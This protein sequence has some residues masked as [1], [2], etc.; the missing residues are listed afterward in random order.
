MVSSSLNKHIKDIDYNRDQLYKLP[1]SENRNFEGLYL[2]INELLDK[3]NL[4]IMNLKNINE[5]LNLVMDESGIYLW[6]LD[7]NKNKISFPFGRKKEIVA[8]KFNDIYEIMDS[9]L[10]KN[11]KSKFLESYNHYKEGICEKI[12]CE[13][14]SK[15]RA[16]DTKWFFI[17]G[18]RSEDNNKNI[19]RMRIKL[20]NL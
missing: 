5:K 13:V 3:I 12:S 8:N 4:A 10:D 15:N 14:A 20:M 9:F 19:K 1:I 2:A 18:K 6:E 17:V 7:E 11:D 16:V